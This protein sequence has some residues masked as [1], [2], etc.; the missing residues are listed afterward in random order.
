LEGKTVTTK[1]CVIWAVIGNDGEYVADAEEGSALEAFE[2][3]YDGEMPRRLL[4]IVL[5]VPVEEP[6]VLQAVVPR[7][8]ASEIKLVLE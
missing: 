2:E 6:L 7:L 1:A 4:K 5:T 8:S 3:T